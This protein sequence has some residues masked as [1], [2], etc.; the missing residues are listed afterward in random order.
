MI[1]LGFIHFFMRI[2]KKQH[3]FLDIYIKKGVEN[4]QLKNIYSQ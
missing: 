4:I 2:M 1:K 3:E